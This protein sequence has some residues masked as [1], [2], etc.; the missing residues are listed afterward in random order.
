LLAHHTCQKKSSRS[1]TR[2]YRK[3][4]VPFLHESLVACAPTIVMGACT[5]IRTMFLVAAGTSTILP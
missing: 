1:S 5:V 2:A 3:R 4:D